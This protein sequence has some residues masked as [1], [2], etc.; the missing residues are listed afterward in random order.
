MRWQ[1]L[2]AEMIPALLF[3]CERALKKMPVNVARVPPS[4]EW[5]TDQRGI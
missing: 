3:T 5:R 1:R 4:K 2:T